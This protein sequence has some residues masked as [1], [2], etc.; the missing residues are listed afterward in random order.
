LTE[1]GDGCIIHNVRR[2]KRV[3]PTGKDGSSGCGNFE[4]KF[5]KPLDKTLKVW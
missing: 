5:E 4:K 2:D 1:I 3:S